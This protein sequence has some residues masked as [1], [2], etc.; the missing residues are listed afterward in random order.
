[1]RICFRLKKKISSA[2]LLLIGLRIL[3][4]LLPRIVQPIAGAP[5]ACTLPLSESGIFPKLA[6]LFF[7]FH[8]KEQNINIFA[9]KEQKRIIYAVHGLVQGRVSGQRAEMGE[10][11]WLFLD[12]NSY[13]AS[14]EQQ[15]ERRLRG[16]PVAVVPAFSPYTTIIA[17]SYEARAFGVKTGMKLGEAQ[18]MCPDIIAVAARHD[19]YVVY[20]HRIRAAIEQHIHI[21]KVCSID[22][23]ACPLLGRERAPGAAHALARRVQGA[24]L[25]EVGECL[26][27]SVGLAPSRL[28][29]KTAS[30]M[31]KPRGITMI[32]QEDLPGPLLSLTLRDLTGIGKNRERRLRAAG[33]HD[34]ATFWNLTPGAARRIWGSIEGEAFWYGLHGVDPPDQAESPRQSIGHS[35]VLMPEMRTPP[36]AWAVGRRLLVAAAARLRLA[37]CVATRFSLHARIPDA[38]SWEREYRFAPTANTFALLRGMD[39]MEADFLSDLVRV[40]IKKIGVTLSGLLPGKG[41]E[42]DL[43]GH[44]AARPDEGSELHLARALDRL[45]QRYGRDAVSIG[46]PPRRIADYTGGKIAFSRIPDLADFAH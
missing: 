4:A 3:A 32:R 31:K 38:P 15:A 36:A 29:A 44:I 21:A 5:M 34:V 1:M 11:K 7:S 20:H 2:P 8:K 46:P 30:T 39:A 43:F 27:S 18:L 35:Q 10:L 16:K 13:F 37:D 12:L 19:V 14:V 41:G 33:I 22:E 17:S 26:G 25:S 45:N 42:A 24:I 9:C 23:V 6:P 28:L 40:R